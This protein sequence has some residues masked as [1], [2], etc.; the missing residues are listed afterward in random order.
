[1]IPRRGFATGQRLFH[2]AVLSR[3]VTAA[4]AALEDHPLAVPVDDL[5]Q[6]FF[7]EG[8]PASNTGLYSA[9]HLS[10]PFLSFPFTSFFQARSFPATAV[11]TSFSRASF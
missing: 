1:M 2:P 7:R 11:T 6:F 8:F 3:P 4:A 5:D 9:F 10:F